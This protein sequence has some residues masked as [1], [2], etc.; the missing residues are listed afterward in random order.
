M[1]EREAGVAEAAQAGRLGRSTTACTKGCRWGSTRR[2]A[3]PPAT[4]RAADRIGTGDRLALQHPH[5]RRPAA[6]ADQQPRPRRDRGRRAPGQDRLPLLREQAEHVRRTR[7]LQDRSRIRSRRRQVQRGPRSQRRQRADHLRGIAMPRLAVLGHPVAH[8]RSP[9]MQNAALAA[10]GLAEE[11]SYEAID[12]APEEFEARVRAM[13]GEGLRRRQR[14]RPAQGGG[15]GA[16]RRRQRGGAGDRRRQHAGLRR[17]AGSQADNTDAGGLLA[18]L[19]R[20]PRGRRALVL[21][22]GG[23]ARAA[24]WALRREGAERRRLEPRPGAPRRPDDVC[25][26]SCGRRGRGRREPR[27]Q[28]PSLRADRQHHRGRPARRGPV[29]APAAAAATASRRARWSSTW[30]TATQPTRAARG[31]R[32]GRGDDGRRPRG[33]GPAGRP[34]AARSGP[35]ASRRST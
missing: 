21:G 22:A 33:P 7:L 35:A 17:R 12:V 31:R 34:L 10:L 2:S 25:E 1:I 16:R 19:P 14:H 28:R 26:P 13:P 4:T 30:S 24:V 20:P 18:S 32:G 6:G 27:R 23:A 11:W 8:S 5:Q 9:A 15:A 3:S 29:R